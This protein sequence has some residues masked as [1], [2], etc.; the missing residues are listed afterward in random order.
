M[1]H[2]PETPAERYLFWRT[3][4]YDSASPF[5]GSY[6]D[7]QSDDPLAV[8]A[9]RALQQALKE[10]S[11]TFH[12][13]KIPVGPCYYSDEGGAS[14]SVVLHA[15][16]IG[17]AYEMGFAPSAPCVR[18]H[19]EI[20]RHRLNP[21]ESVNPEDP[22]DGDLRSPWMLRTRHVAWA[23][24]ML[25]E[26]PRLEVP[27]DCSPELVEW[28]AIHR[29]LAELAYRYLDGDSAAARWIGLQEGETWWSEYW[30]PSSSKDGGPRRF[31]RKPNL[32]NTVY[33]SL[34][35]ARS[36][37]H[38]LQIPQRPWSRRR[39]LPSQAIG[40][41]ADSIT[42]RPTP[43]GPRTR[44]VSPDP[45]YGTRSEL[46]WSEPW[47]KGRDLPPGIVG[48]LCIFLIEY[49]FTVGQSEGQ[50]AGLG[51][52]NLAERLAHDLLSRA[53]EWTQSIELYSWGSTPGQPADNWQIMSYSVC[54]R[55]VLEA[56]VVSPTH[57]SLLEAFVTIQATEH[58]PSGS[59][60]RRDKGQAVSGDGVPATSRRDARNDLASAGAAPAG[61]GVT[62]VPGPEDAT[63]TPTWL[64]VGSFHQRKIYE[65]EKDLWFERVPL[66]ETLGITRV[67]A[68]KNHRWVI[69][70]TKRA[71]GMEAT[72]LSI[73][74]AVMAYASLRRALSREDPRQTLQRGAPE[75]N[76]L[77]RLDVPG[78]LPD[79]RTGPTRPAPNFDRIALSGSLLARD[80]LT[81]TL[82]TRGIRSETQEIAG[83]HALVIYA[84]V[85]FGARLLADIDAV[86]VGWL[87]AYKAGDKDRSPGFALV[88]AGKIGSEMS[89]NVCRAA[90]CD[91]LLVEDGEMRFA[92]QLT[93]IEIGA[94]DWLVSDA[95]VRE[96]FTAICAGRPSRLV[97]A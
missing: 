70:P 44:L 3:K 73:H 20:L 54:L 74:S 30:T 29:E 19:L 62:E 41:L 69:D 77:R 1:P 51:Y 58:R 28:M 42:V 25:A 48:L 66:A 33:A 21:R 53:D 75:D 49:A 67:K 65:G 56:G 32:L 60:Q 92:E 23:L 71:Q 22:D 5:A 76:P 26:L 34:A 11:F 27:A 14:P 85:R 9:Q 81:L 82:E 89:D 45:R 96:A 88:G 4:S 97:Q 7:D 68:G 2:P 39:P 46:P 50:S 80:K 55:A 87:S 52:L 90:G 15:M 18:R 31:I 95:L 61:T 94:V 91:L 43:S 40:E 38:Q 37:R 8:Q 24:A 72:P 6:E 64:D 63:P 47:A 59:G 16:A 57:K 17:C 35:V 79:G 36:E 78:R 13:T 83:K 86:M 12:G 93:S 84:M 10:N